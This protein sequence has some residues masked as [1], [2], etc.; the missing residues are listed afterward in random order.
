MNDA[1]GPPHPQNAKKKTYLKHDPREQTSHIAQC[2]ATHE[3]LP[4]ME[5]P[6]ISLPGAN[7]RTNAPVEVR[8][9]QVP[10]QDKAARG[11]GP[12]KGRSMAK[13]GLLTVAGRPNG[14][15]RTA[16]GC[17]CEWWCRRKR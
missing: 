9:R 11:T 5:T 10:A 7:I 2:Y 12:R 14:A 3:G 1:S 8:G 13:S 6:V 16:R 15:W 17:T 4:W